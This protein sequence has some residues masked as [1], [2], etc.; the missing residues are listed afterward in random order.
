MRPRLANG[1][2]SVSTQNHWHP[3]LRIAWS[4]GG[5]V[6][7][8]EP[9]PEVRILAG[10]GGTIIRELRLDSY[11]A[12]FAAL[13]NLGLP[14]LGATFAHTPEE[15]QGLR[16]PDFRA[17]SVAGDKWLLQEAQQRWRQVA[18]ASWNAGEMA[19]L[20][21]SSRIASGLTY[22]EM[23]LSDLVNAYGNQL[24]GHAA[25]AE[26]TT[27]KR[28]KDLNTPWV[29]K[30]IHALFWELAVLRDSLA[31]FAAVFC[32]SG[33]DI[34]SMK[35]LRKS[36]M[37]R[38]LSDALADEILRATEPNG[39]GW[40]ARFSSYRNLFT[41]LAP[42]E[43]AAG[44]AFAV[45]DIR[46]LRDG[47][48]I[49]QMYYA[50]PANVEEL[51]NKRSKGTLFSTPEELAE[52]TARPRQRASDPDALEYLH[53]CVDKFARFS[54]ALVIRSPI[55]PRRIEIHPEDLRGPV[56]VG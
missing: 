17:M 25:S 20:D 24:R 30:A 23:R 26:P 50:L 6:A 42:V 27:Y 14:T 55:A 38:S 16:P 40:L 48:K 53:G 18:F 32:F 3:V 21:V 34:R 47:L 19:L 10:S 46:E 56:R 52:A 39:P 2:C 1:V 7:I 28:F 41:H 31:Q 11:D 54:E 43:Q 44:S 35:G 15:F 49:P 22:A 9:G 33:P 37:A 8:N 4:T 36:L 29:V 5:I 13:W 12:L 45:Q 51:I